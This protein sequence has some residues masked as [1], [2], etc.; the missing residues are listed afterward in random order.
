MLIDGLARTPDTLLHRELSG[1]G[2]TLDQHLLAL[3]HDQLALANWQ[4]QGK[5]GATRPKP[6]SPLARKTDESVGKADG[7]DQREVLAVLA[8]HAGR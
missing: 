6:L 8:A 2:W 5:K 1:D 4:R 3:V 7:L